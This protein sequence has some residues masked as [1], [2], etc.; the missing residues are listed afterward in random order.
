MKIIITNGR[1]IDPSQGLD[2]PGDVLIEGKRISGIF[3]H[4]KARTPKST[5]VVDASGCIVIPGLVDMHTHLREPG[6]EYKETI[7]TGTMAALHGGFTTVCCMP[8]T[9][10]PNDSISVTRFIMDKVAKEGLCTVY[11]IAAITRGQD[12][13]ALTELEA[14]INA[15]CIAFSDDGRPVMNSLIMRRALEYSKIFDVPIISHCEDSKLSE[16]RVMNEGFISTILGLKGIPKAAEEVMVARDLALCE[17]TK[18]R[19]HIAHVSTAGSVNMIREAKK[20]GI[21]VTAETCPH[22]FTLTDEALIGYDTNLKV[23]PPIRTAEDVEAIKEGLKDDTIDVIATDHAP[24]HYDDKNREFD[25][26]AFGISGLETAFGLNMVLVE[27]GVLD[28]NRLIRKCTITPSNIMRINKGTIKEGAD[29]D[30]TVID[31]ETTYEV[32]TS[33]FL[34]KGKNSPFNK[35]KLKGEIVATVSM[36]RLHK[37]RKT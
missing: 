21:N 11:P 4:G 28:L 9:N 18:G 2:A 17:L 35:W 8:N 14:L 27:E 34:S 31:T 23:N 30:L 3:P 22:Y 15:G 13:E 24:H 37:W 20:R 12:G 5:K 29:A 32:D 25:T 33:K 26:A 10:P 1:V 36:G 7:R 6:Y 19:L 16:G